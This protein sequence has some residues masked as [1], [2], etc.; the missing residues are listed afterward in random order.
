M[1]R[2]RACLSGTAIDRHLGAVILTVSSLLLQKTNPDICL[3]MAGSSTS[4][5]AIRISVWMGMSTGERANLLS[6]IQAAGGQ[7]ELV[8]DGAEQTA[9]S[10]GAGSSTD[11]SKRRRRGGG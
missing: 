1:T 10:S 9:S 2:L 6:S 3:R 4:R 11:H 8:P 5:V 7:M